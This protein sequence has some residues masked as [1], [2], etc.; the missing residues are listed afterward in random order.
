[1]ANQA[2]ANEEE[3]KLDLVRYESLLDRVHLTKDSGKVTQV[4]GQTM[5]GF[6]PGATVGSLCTVYPGPGFEI[7]ASRRDAPR[8]PSA[9]R[10]RDWPSRGVQAQLP[11]P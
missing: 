6:L 10:R 7:P 5:L 9:S 8:N 2:T 3:F 11:S 4:I 1:M